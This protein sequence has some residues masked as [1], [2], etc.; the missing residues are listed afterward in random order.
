MQKEKRKGKHPFYDKIRKI[1]STNN[2]PLITTIIE[3]VSE[4]ESLELEKKLVEI[5]GRTNLGNGPLLNLME[6]GIKNPSLSGVFSPTWKK[7]FFEFWEIKYGEE[8]ANKKLIEYKKNMSFVKKG[9]K[10][11]K[12]TKEKISIKTKKRWETM[13]DESRE[14]LLK[15]ST[16]DRRQKTK[17]FA[18][19]C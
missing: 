10:H 12:E 19:A 11:K 18:N 6:G 16:N 2:E 4:E 17:S 15:K 3:N 14:K 8:E 13:D 1:L 7:S 9:T 5:I